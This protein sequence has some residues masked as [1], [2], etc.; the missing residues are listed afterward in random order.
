MKLHIFIILLVLSISIVHAQEDRAEMLSR[1]AYTQK[2]IDASRVNWTSGET[3]MSRIS[4]MEFQQRL[5]LIFSDETGKE[6]MLRNSQNISVP[7]RSSS[8]PNYVNWQE[9]GCVTSVKDQGSCGSCYA[10]ASCALMESYYL[11]HFQKTL[12]LSEQ[13][14]MMKTKIGNFMGGCKG[15]NLWV[16]AGTCIAFGAPLEECCP[17]KASEEACPKDCTKS[18]RVGCMVT[19]GIDGFQAALAESGPIVVGFMVYE[20]FRDYKTGV[21]K[22][23]HG[24]F[25][26]GH[27][28]LLVGYNK[29]K[30]Y[31]IAKNSWGGDWGESCD[32]KGGEKGY[33][34]IGFGEC[35]I[36][37]AFMGPFHAVNPGK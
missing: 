19:G 36:E 12:D 28:V 16:C 13:Y 4:L 20:D 30:E 25:L 23:V 31:W 34:R 1:I 11:R 18:Y 33:F 29:E 21:Y 15:N 2:L 22:H 6:E 10:F 14:F 5:G 37:L 17:Y 3:S 8:T 7:E 32:G 9:K 26:G 27:A 35:M 24:K